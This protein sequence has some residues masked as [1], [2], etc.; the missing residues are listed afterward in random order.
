MPVLSAR[1]SKAGMSLLKRVGR[2]LCLILVLTSIFAFAP[3]L[4]AQNT[5]PLAM[6]PELMDTIVSGHYEAAQEISGQIASAYP[7][8]PAAL[9][10]RIAISYA[11]MVDFEDTSGRAAFMSLCDS[12]VE[13]CHQR[14]DSRSDDRA[15]LEYLRGSV[16][17][18][19]GLL[20]NH[21]GQ[22]LPALKSLIKAKNSFEQAIEADPQFYDAY[23]GRGAYRYAVATHASLLRWLPFI[24]TKQSGWEDLW[25][26]ARRSSFS[27]AT[28]LTSIVWHAMDEGD[29]ATADSIIQ[30]GLERFP[31]SRNFLWPR[32]AWYER[33]NQWANAESTAKL[34]LDQYLSLPENNGYDAIGLYWRLMTCADNL[35]RPDDAQSY[36]RAG[37]NTFRTEDV[38]RR[39]GGKLRDMQ[40][41]LSKS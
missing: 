37:L 28:A 11:R 34:L 29:F 16:F 22:V 6:Y 41:R 2:A 23:L 18:A 35:G 7:G 1:R 32:L 20:L 24:P 12:C 26:A 27:R 30:A 25:L 31:D 14:L 19:R 33:Q 36:A 40:A 4:Q 21:E 15:N 10:A 9:Y 13:A 17:G 3:R 38:A 5:S 39:R 8:H